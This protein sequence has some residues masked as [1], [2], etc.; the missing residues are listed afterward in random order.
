M[1]GPWGEVADLGVAPLELMKLRRE[2]G[3]FLWW[4]SV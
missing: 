3:G 2:E 1:Q 4:F